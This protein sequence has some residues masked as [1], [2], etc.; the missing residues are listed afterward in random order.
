VR[1]V[2]SRSDCMQSQPY[3]AA[4]PA[5]KRTRTA[6]ANSSRGLLYFA[7]TVTRLALVAPGMRGKADYDSTQLSVRRQPN[8]YTHECQMTFLHKCSQRA[9][10]RQGDVAAGSA[11]ETTR[12]LVL[13]HVFSGCVSVKRGI[14]TNCGITW[15]WHSEAYS[16][17]IIAVNVLKRKDGGWCFYASD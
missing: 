12:R 11:A 14:S 1:E 7:C 6:P 8:S 17:W 15:A 3:K 16:A 13:M 5:Q 9:H 4:A 10:E 2:S